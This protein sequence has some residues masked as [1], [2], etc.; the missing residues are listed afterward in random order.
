[1]NTTDR[2][3]AWQANLDRASAFLLSQLRRSFLDPTAFGV[4]IGHEN[5]Y[6]TYVS[7]LPPLEALALG[8]AAAA[9]CQMRLQKLPIYLLGM[10]LDSAKGQL[11]PASGG[12]NYDEAR[13]RQAR[14]R[15]EITAILRE[16]EDRRR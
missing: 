2:Q 6:D 1:M 4:A 5:S 15:A 3:A 12:E 10:L 14:A 9:A 11:Y 16:L 13:Q 8:V 7:N